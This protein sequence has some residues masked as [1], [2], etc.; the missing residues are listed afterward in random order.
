MT[1]ISEAY[2]SKLETKILLLIS[3]AQKII[4]MQIC[5][6]VITFDHLRPF[7][8]MVPFF[9]FRSILAPPT[10][11]RETFFS[12][13]LKTEEKFHSFSF[14]QSTLVKASTGSLVFDYRKSV[15]EKLSYVKFLTRAA[16]RN[17]SCSCNSSSRN[18]TMLCDEV[19]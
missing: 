8:E 17:S 18:A 16:V 12:I 15:F 19:C 9:S 13:N 10:V 2:F 14:R 6:F 11:D 4:K 1:I 3:L 5:F 7:P